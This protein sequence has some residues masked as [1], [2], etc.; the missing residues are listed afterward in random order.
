MWIRVSNKMESCRKFFNFYNLLI[1]SIETLEKIP[2]ILYVRIKRN[3]IGC[4]YW[5]WYIIT[6]LKSIFKSIQNLPTTSIF[7]K[8]CSLDIEL[9]Y[10]FHKCKKHK[11][12]K[13]ESRGI[14]RSEVLSNFNVDYSCAFQL[15]G[16]RHI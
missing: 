13:T 6:R 14:G 4:L 3:W 5:A 10:F 11:K 1:W 9:F 8:P 2:W 15:N 16:S 7:L 12:W